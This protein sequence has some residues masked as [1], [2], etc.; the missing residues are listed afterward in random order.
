M[1]EPN[2]GHGFKLDWTFSV[3]T[4]LTFLLLIIS[5]AVQY[6]MMSNRVSAIEIVIARQTGAYESLSVALHSLETTMVR[7]Q[8]QMEE[9]ERTKAAREGTR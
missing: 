2:D 1:I 3:S 6:G 7:L 9:R 4:L 5:M 8:T